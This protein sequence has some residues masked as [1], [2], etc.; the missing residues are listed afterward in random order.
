VQHNVRS[1][2]INM[3]KVQIMESDPCK[4]HFH[5]AGRRV[6]GQGCGRVFFTLLCVRVRVFKGKGL[7]AKRVGNLR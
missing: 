5:W 6:L 3:P 7:F 1:G 4:M 2:N